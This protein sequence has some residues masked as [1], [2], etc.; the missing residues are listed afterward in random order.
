LKPPEQVAPQEIPA[1]VDVT[2]PVPA[3]AFE[4]MTA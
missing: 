2:V 3:P 1:G 4:T